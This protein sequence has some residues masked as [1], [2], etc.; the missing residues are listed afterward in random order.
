MARFRPI[1]FGLLVGGALAFASVPSVG[2]AWE[3]SDGW[4]NPDDH[5]GH[6]YDGHDDDGDHDGDHYGDHDTSSPDGAEH[7][8]QKLAE[9]FDVPEKVIVRLRE[10]GMGY[11]EIDHALTL[12][13]RL[14]GGIKRENVR[15]IV[16]MR[17]SGMGWGQIAHELDTTMGA[18]KRDFRTSPPPSEGP[19]AQPTSVS[20]SG[21]SSHAAAR[22]SSSHGL[23]A[24]SFSGSGSKGPTKMSGSNAGRMSATKLGGVS[25]ARAN[26]RAFGGGGGSSGGGAANASAKSGGKA[27]GRK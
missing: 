10:S 6:D 2:T 1:S 27:K 15:E 12:A 25:G 18:A 7:V 11:G 14:P 16:E 21:K 13:D 19:V 8:R 5:D 23:G 22:G 17:E 26:G 9:K 24:K 4:E 3:G 20:R